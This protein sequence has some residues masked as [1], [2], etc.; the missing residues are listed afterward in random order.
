MT[1][2]TTI[3]TLMLVLASPAG[4]QQTCNPAQGTGQCGF[5]GAG[6]VIYN[7]TAEAYA[8]YQQPYNTYV[9]PEPMYIPPPPPPPPPEPIRESRYGA[10]AIYPNLDGLWDSQKMF[11]SVHGIHSKESAR[12]KAL[13]E[14]KRKSG[15][16]CQVFDYADQCL[17]V[18]TGLNSEGLKIYSAVSPQPG[19]APLDAMQ[20]C[21]AAQ[22]K[23]CEYVVQEEC[24]LP[25]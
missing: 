23:E 10:L 13:Q 7:S 22:A 20:Q 11:A 16:S 8:S 15:H 19:Q 6:G 21:L 1:K 2:Q 14:C 24:S 25:E 17:S 9:E 18:T 4:A 12:K 5:L 3:L